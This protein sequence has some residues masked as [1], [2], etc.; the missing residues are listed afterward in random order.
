M[1]YAN[2]LIAVW[3]VEQGVCRHQLASSDAAVSSLRYSASGL[4]L[5]AGHADGHFVAWDDAGELP[6]CRFRG[7][8]HQVSRARAPTPPDELSKRKAE[9]RALRSSVQVPLLTFEVLPHWML[10]VSDFAFIESSNL[11]SASLLRPAGNS[12]RPVAVVTVSK[13]SQ[14][15]LWDIATSVCLQVSPGIEHC[16]LCSVRNGVC[17]ALPGAGAHRQSV[18]Q[19]TLCVGAQL[20]ILPSFQHIN[21]PQPGASG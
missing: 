8:K 9:H 18:P 10:Q 4:I 21:M 13:D 3:D 20:M 1:G 15:R 5:G 12:S 7:H 14:M 2:G 16:A 6:L 17:T 19:I 11:G